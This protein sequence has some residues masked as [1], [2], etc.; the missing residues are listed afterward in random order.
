MDQNEWN[1]RQF[2]PPNQNGESDF[3]KLHLQIEI[4]SS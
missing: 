1:F 4:V 2:P 3:L